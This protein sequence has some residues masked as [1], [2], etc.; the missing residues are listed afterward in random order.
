MPTK[1]LQTSKIVPEAWTLNQWLKPN[2]TGLPSFLMQEPPKRK[3]MPKGVICIVKITTTSDW[4]ES[5][6]DCPSSTDCTF[7]EEESS[8]TSQASHTAC[9]TS[10]STVFNHLANILGDIVTSNIFS[11]LP[12]RS[13]DTSK[14]TVFNHLANIL[15]EIVTSNILDAFDET[16]VIP[17]GKFIRISGFRHTLPLKEAKFY[18]SKETT[19]NSVKYMIIIHAEGKLRLREAYG[20]GGVEIHQAVNNRY[21]DC[22]RN[23]KITSKALIEIY[24]RILYIERYKTII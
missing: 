11:C 9:D 7:I 17:C 10:K 6:T 16:T 4:E 3:R 2:L 14:S 5:S 12:A 15:G 23:D 19:F 18:L 8:P 20:V 22:Y 13:C 1:K 24:K 21:V